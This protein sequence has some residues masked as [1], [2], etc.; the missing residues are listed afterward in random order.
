LSYRKV[1]AKLW[2]SGGNNG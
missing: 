2:R 1:G